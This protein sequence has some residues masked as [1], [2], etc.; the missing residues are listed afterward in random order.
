MIILDADFFR[1]LAP[2]AG[3]LLLVWGGY[4]TY[5]EKPLQSREHIE[6][7]VGDASDGK[8]QQSADRE[9]L[10]KKRKLGKENPNSRIARL[11][12]L[13]EQAN[14]NLT[15]KEFALLSLGLGGLGLVF[16]WL[17]GGQSVLIIVIAMMLGCAGPYLA[18]RIRVILRLRKAAAQFSDILDAMVS[19][20]RSGYGFN[21]AVQM[22]ADNF[23]DPWGV[24][25]SKVGVEMKLGA[26]ME[27]ALMNLTQRIPSADVDLFLTAMLIQK[28]TGGSLAE[29]LGIL[30]KTIRERY[31]L[32]QKIGAISAQ[33]KLSAG[34]VCVIPFLLCGIMFLFLPEPMGKFVTNPIGIV[35]L[36]LA[37]I[38]MGVGIG[39]LFKIVQ[40]EV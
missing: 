30:S 34:I 15:I 5:L 14:W 33:G 9:S 36:T 29:L 17:G 3:V 7:L 32:Y 39:V 20:F 22:V 35:L 18:L 38:W 12:L 27:S 10:L 28:E 16:G 2:A 40:V 11:E 8:K 31:K 26:S 6:K 13:L 19:A 4:K 37:G 1:N 24:E 21:R 23:D 25:F